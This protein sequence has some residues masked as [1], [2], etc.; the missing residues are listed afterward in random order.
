MITTKLYRSSTPEEAITQHNSVQVVATVQS[1]TSVGISPYLLVDK[2]GDLKCIAIIE[3]YERESN[4]SSS[5][6]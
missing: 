1:S 4:T 2:Q 5:N 3:V 6:E